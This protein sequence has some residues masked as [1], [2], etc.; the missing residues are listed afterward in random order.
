MQSHEAVMVKTVLLT[1]CKLGVSIIRVSVTLGSFSAS[2]RLQ[3]AGCMVRL[4]VIPE[5][6]STRYNGSIDVVTLVSLSK[7][8]HQPGILVNGSSSSANPSYSQ[9]KI[10]L[11]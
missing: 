2:R 10:Q 9:V 3:V 4:V 5:V 8:H 1:S 7:T 6:H 11:Y